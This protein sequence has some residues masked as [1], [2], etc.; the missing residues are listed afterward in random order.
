[1]CT[2]RC[3]SHIIFLWTLHILH[4]AAPY[5]AGPL[6]PQSIHWD[7]PLP[8]HWL[9]DQP[10][11]HQQA[12]HSQLRTLPSALCP[13]WL[14]CFCHVHRKKTKWCIV[15]GSLTSIVSCLLQ[16]FLTVQSCTYMNCFFCVGL[17]IMS[18]FELFRACVHCMD[19]NH[20]QM[21]GILISLGS[22]RHREPTCLLGCTVMMWVSVYRHPHK[23]LNLVA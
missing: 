4:F 15:Q 14:I 20:Q 11:L 5:I 18:S 19:L 3:T 17:T 6:C 16:R 22:P 10:I 1:M 23:Y 8:L 12:Y 9:E 21:E 7:F 13:C 2:A